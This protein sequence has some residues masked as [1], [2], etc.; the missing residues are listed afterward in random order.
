MKALALFSGGLD[1]I[2]AI[3]LIQSLEIQAEAL[4]FSNPFHQSPTE[5]LHKIQQLASNLNLKLHI[6]E[7]G[8]DYLRVI[9]HPRYNYGKQMN[10]CV[11]CRIYQLTEA[12]KMMAEIGA[13]FL[14]TGEVLDQR[15][16]SQRRDALDI[17]ERDS[18]LRGYVLRPLSAKHLRPTIPEENGWVDRNQLLDIKGRG[19]D[20]QIGLAKKYG[21]TDYPSP[22]GGCL[23][24]YREYGAKVKDLI[25]FEKGLSL[26]SVNLLQTGRHLRLTPQV[27]I[28]VGKNETENKLLNQLARHNDVIL[29]LADFQGPTTLYQ[30]PAED[31]ALELAAAI[32]AGYSKAPSGEKARVIAARNFSQKTIT[33][34]P[35][36]RT[37]IQ[38]YFVH[39]I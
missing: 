4:Y 24:T 33:V 28:I 8:E 39:N 18:G 14:I 26:R 11:D 7:F 16:H 29:E 34:F 30:G 38:S 13:S 21:I 22:A 19:R 36:E 12:K 35:L 37:A 17:V 1:S 27:K 2:I 3:K 9:E 10:P 31:R 32:T 23:L 20:Q 15:P 5:T 25:Q 6:R